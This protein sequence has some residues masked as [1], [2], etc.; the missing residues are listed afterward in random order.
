[1]RVERGDQLVDAVA[2]DGLALTAEALG[3]PAQTDLGEAQRLG[4]VVGDEHGARG[5]DPRRHPLRQRFEVRVDDRILQGRQG[6]VQPVGTARLR[7]R[8]EQPV[9]VDTGPMPARREKVACQTRSA[10][11]PASG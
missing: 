3:R 8:Q 7:A 1:M 11:S 2:R 5:G 10:R 6:R 4:T 9:P